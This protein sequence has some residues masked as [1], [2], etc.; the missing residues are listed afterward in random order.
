MIL[1]LPCCIALNKNNNCS[2][3]SMFLLHHADIR[4]AGLQEHITVPD[5]HKSPWTPSLANLPL[6]GYNL[7]TVRWSVSVSLLQF[8]DIISVDCPVAGVKRAF[9]SMTIHFPST[10]QS[11]H[12]LLEKKSCTACCSKCKK[13]KKQHHMLLLWIIPKLAARCSPQFIHRLYLS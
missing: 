12:F 9:L 10:T 1:I 5:V 11:N 8:L 3:N 7:L 2:N 6:Q 13:I 4:T